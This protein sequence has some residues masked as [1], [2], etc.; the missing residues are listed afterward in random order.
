[1]RKSN[2]PIKMSPEESKIIETKIVEFDEFLPEVPN[3]IPNSM[4]NTA[5]NS[6]ANESMLQNLINNKGG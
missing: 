5:Q 2:I 6:M 3:S 4:P 1:M